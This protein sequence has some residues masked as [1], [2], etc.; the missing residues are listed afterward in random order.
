MP[1]FRW[2]SGAGGGGGG[3]AFRSTPSPTD[4]ALLV[5]EV[6]ENVEEARDEEGSTAA[7]EHLYVEI[8]PAPPS[9]D[10]GENGAAARSH[11]DAV[12]DPPSYQAATKLP[13]YDESERTKGECER[14]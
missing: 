13:T 4:T 3:N 9:Y 11:D 7:A 10:G 14:Q 8:P 1:W 2:G 5:P 6:A 12:A